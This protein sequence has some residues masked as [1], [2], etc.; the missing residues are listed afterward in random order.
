MTYFKETGVTGSTKDVNKLFNLTKDEYLS[1]IS[2]IGGER[3]QKRIARDYKN[4]SD[5]YLKNPIHYTILKIT[6]DFEYT[7]FEHIYINMKDILSFVNEETNEVHFIEISNNKDD[8]TYILNLIPISCQRDKK[9]IMPYLKK[10][11][12]IELTGGY[13][14]RKLLRKFQLD[15]NMKWSDVSQMFDWSDKEVLN[16]LGQFYNFTNC[17]IQIYDNEGTIY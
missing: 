1:I 5:L 8:E 10:R 13:D 9:V 11:E 6:K 15:F 2:K 4:R 17:A 16:Y 7:Y 14:I 12:T 3:E